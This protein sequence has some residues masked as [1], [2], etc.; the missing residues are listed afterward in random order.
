MKYA[1][2]N[3]CGQ[4]WT[5]SC[6]GAEQAREEYDDLAALPREVDGLSIEVLDEDPE[7]LQIYYY[8]DDDDETGAS[9]SAKVRVI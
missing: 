3:S 2:E 5:G 6:F 4:W 8:G 9:Y 7:D 1:I